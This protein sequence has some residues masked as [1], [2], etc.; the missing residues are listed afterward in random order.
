MVQIQGNK[1][2][3]S[4]DAFSLILKVDKY[5]KVETTHFGASV[6]LEDAEALAVDPAM[7]WGNSILY[8]EGDS[9]SCLERLPLF[10][11]EQGRGD[12][13]ESPIELSK[14]GK[15]FTADFVFDSFE[16]IEGD[17]KSLS[18]LPFAQDPLSTVRI[19]LKSI[20]GNLRLSH[21]VSVFETAVALRTLLE[22]EGE[23]VT[24]SKIGSFSIDIPGDYDMYSFGGGWIAEG[25]K[26]KA[27]I[28][29]AR[30]V[31]ESTYGFSSAVRNPGVMVASLGA[32][33]D[34]GSVYGINYV[35]SGNHY[36]SAQR[37]P[38]GLTRIVGG[39][40][41]D[42]FS[43]E[44]CEGEFFETPQAVLTFS[45]RGFNGMS[46]NMHS[47][48]TEHIVPRY[49]AHRN[50]PIV[51]NSWEGSGFDFSEGKLVSLARKAAALGC[52]TFVLDDGWFGARNDD[53]AGLGD[54]NVNRKKL[55]GGIKRLADKVRAVGLDFGLWFEPEGVNPDSDLYRKHP[56]WAM[57]QEGL[58]DIYGR[59]QLLLDLRIPEV[60]DYI[61]ENVGEIIDRAEIS[62]VKWDM[63][64]QSSLRGY[65]AHGY[66]LGL[67][68]VLKRIFK[69]RPHVLLESCSSGGNRFDLGMFCFG[70]QAWTSDD[71]DPVE[72]LDI[73][74]GMSYLYPQSCISAHVSASPH[75]Q[76]LRSTPVNMRFNVSAFGILGYELN[77]NYIVPT[78]E[79]AIKEQMDF[80]KAHR[81]A[82]QFG[83][84]RRI[85]SDEGVVMWQVSG[86]TEHLLG[87]FHRLIH[88][89]PGY[90][91]IKAYVPEGT[92][93]VK[94]RV[95]TLRVGSFGP[96]LKH[97]T[98]VE[99]NPNGRVVD[100]ADKNYRMEDATF[101]TECSSKA[102]ASGI[103]IMNLFTGTGYSDKIRAQKDFG[104]NVFVIKEKTQKEQKEE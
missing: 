60:R 92:Y 98:P 38:Q 94:S 29:Q 10:Y 44:L 13:R 66:I 61:V 95:Q 68:D 69:V 35:Y 8:E 84:F 97:V 14:G 64:R 65:E 55:P 70:P 79:K 103:P 51:Y 37:S 34:T 82:L 67:Y 7:G 104:S 89:A 1:L 53:H 18:G 76:T 101:K 80:Y 56:E 5:G 90:E 6:D 54:Y 74:E 71:T 12:F 21:F 23:P 85:R 4:N 24:V 99:F 36:T 91:Y 31:N 73:Q 102:L 50:R 16:E 93:S 43:L 15:P 77:L 59:N 52:E 11:S 86:K 47:F 17:T 83:T 25:H 75:A 96:L 45:D 72:R 19:N 22:N 3:I 33:E 100:I 87:I 28:D 48:V 41:P 2:Y 30:V 26:S 49:W 88:A 78:E 40:S 81:K 58:K 42:S 39:I 27:R 63:N 32:T 9:A 46:S 57:H 62:F 20:A